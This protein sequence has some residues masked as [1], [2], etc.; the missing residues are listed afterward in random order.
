[1]VSFI[2][3]SHPG[4]R[5]TCSFIELL[6]SITS[7]LTTNKQH[8]GLSRDRTLS[9]LHLWC[10]VFDETCALNQLLSSLNLK[11]ICRTDVP[12]C[13]DGDY[14]NLKT[15]SLSSLL[16]ILTTWEPSSSTGAN[17]TILLVWRF[18][19]LCSNASSM[20]NTLANYRLQST[21][22]QTPVPLLSLLR[23]FRKCLVRNRAL[24]DRLVTESPALEI[25]AILRLYQVGLSSE[26]T[27]LLKHSEDRGFRTKFCFAVIRELNMICLVLFAAV[28]R[29][30]QESDRLSSHRTGV[31]QLI[32]QEPYADCITN[33]LEKG[34]LP[35]FSDPSK[36][37]EEAIIQDQG[38]WDH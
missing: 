23:W 14:S 30:Q 37:L 24:Q 32:S 33:G 20:H 6:A 27:A 17:Q 38:K 34:I 15:I 18:G 2:C 5:D 3:R 19:L 10:A 7:H 9:L 28:R 31:F 35:M 29:I 22:S 4:A 21:E 12:P 13:T 36:D 26:R 16:S 8:S 11:E 25:K 1:M